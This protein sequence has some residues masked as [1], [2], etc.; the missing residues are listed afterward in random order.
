MLSKVYAST[1]FGIDAFL[2]EVE[3]HI[4]K[5]IPGV[6]IVGLPDSAV[7]E[8][9]ER[10][11]AAITNCGIEF[12]KKKVT[13]NLAPA[14]IK[15]E[16]SA[17]DLP[18]AI[19]ILAAIEKVQFDKLNETLLLGE[20]SLDG[21]LR[22]I[23]GGL[24][25]AVEAKK[26]G[27]KNL[28]LPIDSVKEASIVEGLNVYGM[29]SLLDVIA[30]LNDDKQFK[31]IVTS[32]EEVFSKVNSYDLDFSDVKGQENVKRALE[33]AAAGGHNIL[34]IGPPGS[35]KTM[36]AK[37]FPSILPPL[38]FEEA[39]ETTKIHSVAGILS[40]EQALITE[41]PFRSPHHTVS[42]AAL[43]G[44][45]TFPRPGEVSFAHHGV[46]FLDELP[47]FKKNVLEVMR[48]PME[49]Y[50]VTISRSKMSLE[51]PANF[52][53]AAAMN[54]C[55][56]GFYTDPNRECTCNSGMIQKYMSKISGPLL[57]RIDIHIEVPAVKYKEL[58]SSAKGE[59]SSEI[60]KRVVKARELQQRRFRETPTI[61]N[62]ADMPT[63]E[64]RKYCRLD[65]QSS[66]LLKMAMTKLG[67]SARAYDRILKVS[68][69]IADLEGSENIQPAHI[70]EAIQYRSL[71]R[72]LWNH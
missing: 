57:D 64:I 36:L 37:R 49:D 60:R 52:M 67:L 21:S 62:N 39:I 56:C 45:G 55:P 47:E 3:T 33:V 44:G 41:R 17:F 13:I 38:T 25:I 53:L 54:P 14:D 43:I 68:R 59:P 22:K 23:K 27:M 50:K 2:V 18:I 46:L 65:E 58:S 9:R 29:E 20:L 70:S 28:I 11:T 40:K 32:K 48:Q 61:H 35:G 31:P 1:T 6:N 4:E 8:S 69:T 16:G 26:N 19:G 34:M 66:E 24:P 42:D 10:V 15:K 30:F 51:F 5:Q 7:K 12:P 63:R 71:D 72:E